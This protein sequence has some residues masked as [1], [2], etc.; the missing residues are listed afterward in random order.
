[1]GNTLFFEDVQI[2]EKKLTWKEIMSETSTK[3]SKE[4]L[5]YAMTS[6]MA[7]NSATEENMLQKWHKP[8]VFKRVGLIGLGIIVFL[9]IVYFIMLMVGGLLPAIYLPAIVIPP[10]VV[11][12]TVMIFAWELNIPK[13]LSIYD[14]LGTFL[15]GGIMS[16]AISVLISTLLMGPFSYFAIFA[17]VSE[18]PGKLIATIIMLAYFS[19]KRNIKVY[20]ITALVIG[21]AVGSG[22]SAFESIQ[23][24]FNGEMQGLLGG[25]F[26]FV[27]SRLI[28]SFSGHTLYCAIYAAAIGISCFEK[29]RRF[30]LSCIMNKKVWVY[31]LLSCLFHM[32]WNVVGMLA[33]GLIG[34]V[35][36]IIQVAVQWAFLLK[37]IKKCL[38]QAVS[39]GD[40]VSGSGLG[41]YTQMANAQ[42][43]IDAFIQP[44]ASSQGQAQQ[45][46]P[47]QP[48]QMNRP[49]NEE[50][51][52]A[53]PVETPINRTPEK[54]TYILGTSTK[55]MSI[56]CIAGTLQGREWSG[57]EGT[58]FVFGRGSQ[59]NVKFPSEVKSISREHCKICYS[60]DGWY[61]YDLNSTNGTYVNG[62]QIKPNIGQRLSGTAQVSLAKNNRELFMVKC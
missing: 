53:Q 25:A 27:F 6:G 61:I 3:H 18:E 56:S 22:F 60:N 15:F 16:I 48:Q 54:H 17:F 38:A 26:T 47:I 51:K 57:K 12:V 34:Y 52:R 20:G 62:M 24:V 7:I 32:V 4:E 46:L 55:M 43:N 31:F 45:V 37:V 44:Q 35:L 10:L 42:K 14:L 8:W 19:R 1:M 9:Y 49:S 33:G 2:E 29:N 11:P 59:C 36:M 41:Y 50:Y 28:G 30:K 40:Y 5:E 39:V 21:A 23:Y 13:N 58:E